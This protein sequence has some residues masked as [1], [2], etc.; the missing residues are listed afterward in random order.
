MYKDILLNMVMYVIPL[1][2]TYHLFPFINSNIQNH[3]GGV[4]VSVLSSSVVDRRF[5][6]RSG[7]PKTVILVYFCFSAKH[8]AISRK[9]SDWLTRNHDNVSRVGLHGYPQTVVS[10]E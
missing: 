6:F 4:M 7:E 9:K 2:Y 8:T 10:E 5:K 3:V 1:Y